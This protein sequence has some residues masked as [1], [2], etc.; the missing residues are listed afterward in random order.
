MRYKVVPEPGLEMEITM[1]NLLGSKAMT[2]SSGEPTKFAGLLRDTQIG[3]PKP[4]AL[5]GFFSAA[6]NRSAAAAL[7]SFSALRKVT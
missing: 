6:I 5:E 3:A 2:A 4:A 1:G 7:A